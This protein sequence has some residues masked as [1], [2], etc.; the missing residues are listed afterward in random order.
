MHFMA[1]LATDGSS[2]RPSF[3]ASNLNENEDGPIKMVGLRDGKDNIKTLIGKDSWK[4]DK[5]KYQKANRG[6]FRM[7]LLSTSPTRPIP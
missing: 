5:E 7:A 3:V 4:E 6:N 2:S 1:I